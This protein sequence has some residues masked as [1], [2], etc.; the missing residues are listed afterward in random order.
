MIKSQFQGGSIGFYFPDER[1]SGSAQFWI[2]RVAVLVRYWWVDEVLV[3]V[4]MATKAASRTVA[5]A[6]AIAGRASRACDVCGSKSARWYCGADAAYL[7]DRCDTQVHS[8]N[9]LAQRH[10][11]VRLTP[12]GAPMKTTSAT[13]SSTPKTAAKPR[14]APSK[15]KK[16]EN[17]PPP[18]VLP[19]R[20]RSRTSRPHPHRREKETQALHE[21]EVKVEESNLF[22][23]FFDTEDFLVQDDTQEVPSFDSASPSPS[24]SPSPSAS[25]SPSSSDYSPEF[26]L[27]PE[28]HS[29]LSSP[30]EDS[31]AA[32]FK[33]KAAHD[34]FLVPNGFDSGIDI[35]CCDADG[36]I[37]LAGDAC[38][39]P[40]D[41]PGLE[42]FDDCSLSFD[43]ARRGVASSEAFEGENATTTTTTSNA[44]QLSQPLPP[45]PPIL[46]TFHFHT[47]HALAC[48]ES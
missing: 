18:Q 8:A 24:P 12:S 43:L 45:N 27:S 39:I 26:S 5:T 42:A 4:T 30:S 16:S 25:P 32:Y 23:D 15:S 22:A 35:I 19:L 20:K 38:F 28:F 47:M 36:N 9:S 40:A 14:T 6:M 1:V 33:G 48:F 44:G 46:Q 10:E 17:P 29:D 11:R 34:E 13:K 7:C 31:F 3:A 41:I 21:V 2:S 37:S